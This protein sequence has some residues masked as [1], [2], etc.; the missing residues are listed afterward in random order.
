MSHVVQARVYAE[1]MT[2]KPTLTDLFSER[3][4]QVRAD[5]GAVEQ[6]GYK[7]VKVCSACNG[8]VVFVKSIKTDKWYLA[9]CFPYCNDN[10]GTPFQKWFYVK[11]A[12]HFKSCE[13][14]QNE[15]KS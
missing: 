11:S 2:N 10:L 3:G 4:N 15:K 9:D 8:K 7:S 13:R 14:R 12:P 6:D 1:D 5:G